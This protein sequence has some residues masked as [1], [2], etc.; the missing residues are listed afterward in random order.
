MCFRRD[1][2][3]KIILTFSSWSKWSRGCSFEESST[4]HCLLGFSLT[5]P[6]FSKSPESKTMLSLKC[7]IPYFLYMMTFS[8]Y[9]RFH[10]SLIQLNWLVCTDYF[11]ICSPFKQMIITFLSLRIFNPAMPPWIWGFQPVDLQVSCKETFLLNALLYHI[12]RIWWLLLSTAFIWEF[13]CVS[14]CDLFRFVIKGS[15]LISHL[16]KWSG[17]W[18]SGGS[19]AQHCLLGFWLALP[20]LSKEMCFIKMS[21]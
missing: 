6:Q 18:L 8:L 7:F 19:S 2:G 10:I 15:T 5:C 3:S 11:N 21:C 4:Q 13:S 12:S 14:L 16:S 9:W 1:L 17:C 20:M